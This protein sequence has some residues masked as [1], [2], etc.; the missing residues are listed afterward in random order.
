MFASIMDAKIGKKREKHV[1]VSKSGRFIGNLSTF[2]LLILSTF[3]DVNI[4]T[5][6]KG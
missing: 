2:Y 3:A 1:I 6:E 5:D 4:S